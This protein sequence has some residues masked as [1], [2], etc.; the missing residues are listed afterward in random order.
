VVEASKY[1]SGLAYHLL[2]EAKPRV[3]LPGVS[4]SFISTCQLSHMI[5]LSTHYFLPLQ[6]NLNYTSVLV[7]AGRLREVT[8]AVSICDVR[9]V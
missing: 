6:C 3:A 9:T 8:R 5:R 2:S 4:C 7:N 1:H